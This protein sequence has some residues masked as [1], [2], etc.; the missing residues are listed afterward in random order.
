MPRKESIEKVLPYESGTTDAEF[1]KIVKYIE[2]TA[3]HVLFDQKQNEDRKSKFKEML[4]RISTLDNIETSSKNFV[5]KRTAEEIFV[6]TNAK[7]RKIETLE[8][9]NEI[10]LKIL[11]YLDT[12]DVF[13]NFALVCKKFNQLSKSPTAV[14]SLTFKDVMSPDHYK[15]IVK[16]LKR[17]KAL[18]CIKFEGYYSMYIRHI[19]DRGFKSCPKL[20]SLLFHTTKSLGIYHGSLSLSPKCVETIVNNSQKLERL[21]LRR[22]DFN[23]DED[24]VKLSD[25]KNLK[26]LL[27]RCN[28]KRKDWAI[29]SFGKNCKKLEKVTLDRIHSYYT[30]TQSDL[31]AFFS[32]IKS[33]LN[34][35]TINKVRTTGPSQSKSDLFLKNMDLCEKLEE[36]KVLNA[37]FMT[38]FG[39]NVI[40]LLPKLKILELNNLGEIY[41]CDLNSFFMNLKKY[42]MESLTITN[43]VLMTEETI[44]NWFKYGCGFPNLKYLKIENCANLRLQDKSFKFLIERGFPKIRKMTLH[45]KIVSNLS[46]TMLTYVDKS[47]L[48]EI[49]ISMGTSVMSVDKFVKS[50]SN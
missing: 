21:E 42:H 8:L 44:K 40:A 28:D 15:Q 24:Y 39:L 48:L 5:K 7:K 50:R 14:K 11:S 34:S 38:D 46:D 22:V 4:H 26:S 1:E 37:H 10:W 25:L 13:L 31:H 18:T 6:G 19:V 32:N 41:E 47:Y 3:E 36:I 29:K 9:P 35:L 2:I 12:K 16:V 27:I 33:S 30:H 43:C 45:W 17:S 20:K 49:D 23:R